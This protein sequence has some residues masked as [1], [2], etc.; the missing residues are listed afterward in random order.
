[1]YVNNETSGANSIINTEAAFVIHDWAWVTCFKTGQPVAGSSCAP[2]NDCADD[3][4]CVPSYSAQ[5][6]PGDVN[7]DGV[8]DVDDHLLLGVLLEL[9][10]EDVNTDGA[11]DV[12]D[13][14]AVISAWGPCL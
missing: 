2:C 3:S 5:G 11:I 14:L 13:L 6:E 10:R 9:C 1:M 4:H 12:I 7:H 8:V